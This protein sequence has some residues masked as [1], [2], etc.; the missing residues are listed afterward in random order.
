MLT[1]LLVVVITI[2]VNFI[3]VYRT[4]HGGVQALEE[5]LRLVRA[6]RNKLLSAFENLQGSGQYPSLHA[7]LMLTQIGQQLTSYPVDLI[8]D[9]KHAVPCVKMESSC[10][11]LGGTRPDVL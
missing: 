4:M 8:M 3:M 9:A 11:V 5:R 6:Q 1:L 10:H 7:M 2:I